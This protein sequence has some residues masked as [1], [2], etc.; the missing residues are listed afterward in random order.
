MS[1]SA[2]NNPASPGVDLLARQME[3]D[4]DAR[5]ISHFLSGDT[6]GFEALVE[7]YRRRAYAIALGLTGNH[8]D[9]D[10]VQ[11]AFL[12]LWR[13][14]PRFR[15]GEPFFPWL[16][17]IVRNAA[18]NQARDERRHRGQV[19]LEWVRRP[20]GHPSPLELTEAANLRERLWLGIQALPV[21]QREVFILHHFQGMK[22]RE[23]AAA[24]DIPL[25][26]VMS[27]LHAA[28]LR[29]RGVVEREEVDP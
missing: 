18:L 14:L 25:G 1:N 17:R 23:I 27:R 24:M 26:T 4:A 10:A 16:Y 2:P 9:M 13:A 7:R 3:A 6:R 19:P 28:R 15:L 12:R 20:D 29:L 8:D 22:Y 11:K 5:D 21:E